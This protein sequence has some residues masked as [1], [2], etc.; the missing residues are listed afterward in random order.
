MNES[1]NWYRGNHLL[2]DLVAP[3]DHLDP[4]TPVVMDSATTI[5]AHM[6]SKQ[7]KSTA[8][9]VEAA[10]ALTITLDDLTDLAVGDIIT[11]EESDVTYTR[12]P[13]TV[14]D[15]TT[16]VVTFTTGLT[17]GSVIGARVWKTYGAAVVTGVAYGTADVAK[18]D[19]GYV[20]DFPYTY[21]TEI[22]RNE[23]LEAMTVLHKNS[24]S[25]HY[26]KLWDV[27]QPEAYGTS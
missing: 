2:L 22:L 17:V 10:A 20:F 15:T 8:S 21:D 26:E 16:K 19:W 11:I 25:A 18:D 3:L 6:F 7:T 24:T 5:Q 14:I 9:K 23:L 1:A 12:H 13:V 4:S 27:M